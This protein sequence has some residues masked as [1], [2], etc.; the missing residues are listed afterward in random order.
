M[1]ELLGTESRER[2]AVSDAPSEPPDWRRHAQRAWPLVAALLLKL[3]LG[4]GLLSAGFHAVSDDDFA[5][6]FIAQQFAASPKLDPSGTSWLPLPFWLN[7]GAMRLFGMSLT[8]ARYVAIA[9]GLIATLLI[10]VSARW[11]RMS[12]VEAALGAALSG[13][14]PYAMVLGV[15][16]VPE[17]LTAAAVVAASVS[18]TQSRVWVRGF[19]GALL[20]AATLSRY[21]AWPVAAGFAALTLWDARSLRG[22]SRAGYVAAATLSLTGCLG[23][24]LHGVFHHG[25]ATFFVDR[26]ASYRRAIGA[27]PTSLW[28]SLLGY[29]LSLLRGEPELI[30]SA[31]LT[32][33]WLLVRRLWRKRAPEAQGAAIDETAEA[34]ESQTNS[35][36]DVLAQSPPDS[37]S[38]GYA[39][40]ASDSLPDSHP[41][42]PWLRPVA[43][44]A[45]MLLSLIYGDVRDGAPT[46]HP[47]RAIFA[48]WL[49]TALWLPRAA[50]SAFRVRAPNHRDGHAAATA[51]PHALHHDVGAHHQQAL[52]HVAA[53]HQQALH[54]D[55]GA[56]FKPTPHSA[57]TAAPHTT[58]IPRPLTTQRALYLVSLCAVIAVSALVLRPWYARRDAFIDRRDALAIGAAAR[59]A[60]A[61]GLGVWSDDYG[62]FAVMVG[63]EAPAH[64]HPLRPKP[65][66]EAPPALTPALLEA[67]LRTR[68]LRWAVI[69]AH[70]H[71]ALGSAFP[72]RAERGQWV[73]VEGR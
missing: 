27:A 52:H 49:L 22:R 28:D 32:A 7:G 1:S 60:G 57:A 33:L 16:T 63:F 15:A 14:F 64:A 17:A 25:N 71:Q 54:R 13:A 51:A 44:C 31:L 35:Q 34:A 36:P 70:H 43:L 45:V 50:L 3:A 69:P 42:R 62:F 11:L 65:R 72:A 56:G 26:V 30:G 67:E 23:W 4:L 19:G 2:A 18:C 73:L 8:T 38:G 40:D 58:K 21:E 10:Y 20:G 68:N 9:S 48:L 39:E 46:H 37:R 5:R 61:D 47:E 6:V 41:W 29:P 66:G 55:V 24:V 12:R 53:L 59:E